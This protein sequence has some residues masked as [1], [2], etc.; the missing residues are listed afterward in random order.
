MNCTKTRPYS[1]RKETIKVAWAY[2]FQNDRDWS[3]L[4]Q[5]RSTRFYEVKSRRLCS[6]LLTC[7]VFSSFIFFK[8]NHGF[9]QEGNPSEKCFIDEEKL[10]GIDIDSIANLEDSPRFV[11]IDEECENLIVDDGELTRGIK[12]LLTLQLGRPKMLKKP[13]FNLFGKNYFAKIFG[14]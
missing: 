13:Y 9:I 7:L 3:R 8:K 4:S 5:I 10:D 1:S 11:F 14:L 6:Q 12:V 2:G